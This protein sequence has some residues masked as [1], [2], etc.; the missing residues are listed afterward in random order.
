MDADEGGG[1]ARDE[2][3]ELV[4]EVVEGVEFAVGA[5]GRVVRVL[6]GEGKEKRGGDALVDCVLSDVDEEEGKHVGEE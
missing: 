3:A 2:D 4:E 5:E 6:A 1:T